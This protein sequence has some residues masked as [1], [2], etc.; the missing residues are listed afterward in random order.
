MRPL[1]AVLLDLHEDLATGKLQLRRGRVS[2]TVD[3]VNGN[4]V[5][6]SSTPRDETLGHFLVNSGVITEDDHKK[7]VERATTVGGKLGEALVA[8]QI[9]N[10]EQLIEQLG[11]QAR[12]K[13][14]QALRWP[15]GA[16]RFDDA[17]EAIEGMQLRMIDVVIGGL[18]ET[19]IE[20]LS[21]LQRLD[22]LSFELTERGKRL[23][24]DLRKEFGERG[25]AIL[26]AGAPMGEIEKAFGD[27]AQARLAVDA[28]LM[29]DAIVAKVVQVG[30][31]AGDVPRTTLPGVQPVAP[32]T[33][34]RDKHDEDD[35]GLYDVLFEDEEPSAEGAV[36]LDFEDEDSGVVQPHEIATATKQ[37][38][39]LASARKGVA[40]EHQRISGADHY[41][42]LLVDRDASADDVDAAFQV[43]V[44]LLEK[45]TQGLTD[46]SDRAKLSA[47]R[48]AYQNAR[49][50]LCDPRKRVAYDK[51]LAGG[52]LVQ[53]P[54]A[55]DTELS[56]RRAEAY[57]AKGE[58][59]QAVGL[60]R[61]VLAKSPGEADYH[62][63]I[64]W[65]VWNAGNRELA[66]ADEARDHLNHALSIN[67]D[68]AAAHDYK[69][70]VDAALRVD[71]AAA[72]FH[73]ERALDLEP[74]RKQTLDAVE[75]LLLAKGDVRRFERVLKRTCF[76]LRG[77]GGTPEAGAYTRLAA[78]YV[79]HLDDPASAQVA[80]A[81]A[82]KIAP[83]NADIAVLAERIERLAARSE[84]IRAGWRDAL[85]D[86]QA[87]AQLVRN[88]VAAG[89][90]DAAF[91]AASTMV[92]LGTADEPMRQIYEQHKATAVVL[93]KT[94][95]SRDH[96]S[97]LRHRDDT[98]ELGGLVEL[99]APAV[100]A[101]A[102]MMLGDA[103]LD[104]SQEVSDGELPVAFARLRNQLAILLGVPAAPVF[105]RPELGGQIHVV[106]A[107]PAVLVA[108]DEALTAPERPELVYKLARAMTFLWPG[109]AVGASRPG[110][111]LRAVVLAI[112]RDAAG[113]ELG[114]EDPLAARA[115]QAVASLTPQVMAQARAAALRLLSRQGGG[116]NLSAW[117]K[118]LSR[119][120]DRAGLLLCGDIPAAFVGAREISDLDKDLVEFAYSAA[121]VT[122]R[123]MLAL[124]AS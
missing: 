117:A 22:S 101:L 56:F 115:Q 81:N 37:R 40:A 92:A 41:A 13:L 12:H 67:P 3:L 68:H 18:R 54:P 79:E 124:N 33:R 77:R 39:R 57:M 19:A 50:V 97:V 70:R 73:L 100:Q 82:K 11:R 25:M 103:D 63:A 71:E 113:T 43:K 66:A 23:R 59:A 45:N 109:R 62:A 55:I 7:A 89:H 10:I 51:E 29:C 121:H 123:R 4:P 48:T 99:V 74:T 46:M 6:T 17:T 15:Q 102:P 34:T 85:G 14:V 94:P 80:I 105:A 83:R 118:S 88:T 120:A 106:A 58:W 111:V 42:I 95:L 108:G 28:M 24:H 112:V 44:A 64:G 87:G 16:W 1:P 65:A 96:W 31:G 2:K 21:K 9:L 110:R 60:L 76:R 61:T 119:T 84:P 47:I 35:Q 90:A 8:L 114:I 122:L 69:G 20:D 49:T 26:S 75:D 93:P 5:S 53:V 98:V 116:L 27:R 36:P 86:P 52:E 30:L 72:L 78:L 91:L 104:A 32:R 107:E 38:E